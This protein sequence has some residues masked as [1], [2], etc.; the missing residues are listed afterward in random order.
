M[1]RCP[2]K[3]QEEEVTSGAFPHKKSK[4]DDKEK[5][6]SEAPPFKKFKVDKELEKDPSQKKFKEREELIISASPPLERYRSFI[7]IMF[8]CTRNYGSININ[9]LRDYFVNFEMKDP[10]SSSEIDACLKT[11]EEENKILMTD[12]EIYFI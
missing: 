9:V 12:D 10:F 11:F 7:K 6:M 1:L 8:K 3:S 2:F 4:V 5:I